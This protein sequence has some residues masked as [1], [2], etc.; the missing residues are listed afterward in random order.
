MRTMHV[1][2]ALLWGACGM[3]R[4]ANESYKPMVNGLD[5]GDRSDVFWC[6]RKTRD[7]S[8]RTCITDYCEAHAR[9]AKGDSCYQCPQGADLRVSYAFEQEPTDRRIEACLAVSRGGAH[10]Q[11]WAWRAL[12][13]GGNMEQ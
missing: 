4:E 7:L 12:G 9:K 11:P 13:V 6:I 2:G 8:E 1:E 5:P 3:T 10:A